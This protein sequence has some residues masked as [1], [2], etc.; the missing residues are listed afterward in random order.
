MFITKIPKVIFQTSRTKQP[1]YV[2]DLIKSR[3]P[4][5]EYIHFTDD[6]IFK[7]F[8]ENTLDDFPDMKDK[9]LSIKRL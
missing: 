8:E 5:W 9:F 4:G 1:E 7:F 2:I 6:D 3:S